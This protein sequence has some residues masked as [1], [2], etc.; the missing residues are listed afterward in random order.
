MYATARKPE[1]VKDTLSAA[2]IFSFLIP[3]HA[4]QVR[5]N[6][7]MHPLELQTT[8]RN[9][10]ITSRGFQYSVLG[11][12]LHVGARFGYFQPHRT[13][14]QYKREPKMGSQT[15]LRTKKIKK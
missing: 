3:E 7:V 14:E 2:G 5:V 15:F 9:E 4:E 8:L 12:S 1:K 6:K 13:Q 11:K 10:K